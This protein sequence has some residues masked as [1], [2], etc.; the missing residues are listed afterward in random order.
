MKIRFASV[1]AYVLALALFIFAG[2]VAF[3]IYLSQ[4]AN[5]ELK[6]LKASNLRQ[7][8]LANLGAISAS[9]E[10]ISMSM[11]L[12]TQGLAQRGST[13]IDRQIQLVRQKMN[14]LAALRAAA[15][16]DV[17]EV[18]RLRILVESGIDLVQRVEDTYFKGEWREHK[19]RK[20]ELLDR[21]DAA[22]VQLER[23]RVAISSAGPTNVPLPEERTSGFVSSIASV[24]IGINLTM[25]AAAWML[26]GFIGNRIA[27]VNQNL[28]SLATRASFKEL[29]GNDEVADLN[30]VLQQVSQKLLENEKR[31]RSAIENA[32]DVICTIDAD[33]KF[34]AIN[35]SSY[36][37]FG[38]MQEEL[39]GTRYISLVAA[40]ARDQVLTRMKEIVEQRD[41][42]PFDVRMQKKDGSDVEMLWSARWSAREKS[43]FA[44]LHDVTEQKRVE[45]LLRESEMRIRTVIEK[46]PIGALTVDS[47]GNVVSANP[48]ARSIFGIS[49]SAAVH[50][51][52]KTLFSSLKDLSSDAA[53]EKLKAMAGEHEL[54]LQGIRASGDVFPVD[55]TLSP[56][57][58]DQLPMHILTVKDATQRHEIARLKRD[59]VNMISHDLRTP[60][61]SINATLSVLADGVY[62]ELSEPGQTRVSKAR[63]DVERL[64]RLINELLDLEKL[65]AGKMT[66]RL[67]NV[68]L[69][70]LFE[71]SIESVRGMANRS[72]VNLQSSCAE[73][74]LQADEERMIQVIVNLLSNA[75]KFSPPDST[76]LLTGQMIEPKQSERG[77]SSVPA[78][79]ISVTDTGRGI[80]PA[81]LDSIFER[82]KQVEASDSRSGT[83]IGLVI[84]KAIVELHGGSIQVSSVVG[85]GTTFRIRLPHNSA[86]G[87]HKHS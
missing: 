67:A 75:I 36:P 59:F 39:V 20:L 58:L 56:C 55:L 33:G 6:A 62:G 74:A 72:K 35:D 34:T 31:E 47:D 43:I 66:L 2:V 49:G 86:A 80:P 32:S 70:D 44:V 16:Q 81:M 52:L 50:T 68:R 42:T 77:E 51:S 54:E 17:N 71:R 40:D 26:I 73:L 78:L 76:V 27:V 63:Q 25:L 1:H 61:T 24:F 60:L 41:A 11:N 30:K 3:E 48:S 29:D 19:R 9:L 14:D 65:E 57:E 53:R 22:M 28:L 8:Q 18:E 87:A 45:R 79:E 21:S 23:M 83:G 64:I 69:Q 38:Y 7:E 82:F 5:S 84:C 4:A 10:N 46:L 85:Q 12:E 13:K 15:A 37:H